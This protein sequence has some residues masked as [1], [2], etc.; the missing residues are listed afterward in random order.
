V[1]TIEKSSNLSKKDG[2][3]VEFIRVPY[4]I[5]KTARAIEETPLP[6]VYAFMLRKAY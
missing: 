4:D 6:D 1:I 2:I 5:E 3:K